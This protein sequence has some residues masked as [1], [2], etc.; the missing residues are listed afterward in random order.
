[1]IVQDQIADDIIKLISGAMDELRIGDPAS[2]ATDIGPII[3]ADA[4]ER[5]E[6]H[7]SALEKSGRVIKRMDVGELKRHGHFFGPV[8]AELPAVEELQ[9]ETFGPIIHIVRY[10]K[11]GYAD[12]ARALAGTGYGLTLGV[13][14]RLKSFQQHIRD[15]VPAGNVYV[16]R[17]IIGAVVGVQPF[18]GLGRSGTGPKAGGPHALLP[19]ATERVLTVNLLAEGADP[20]LLAL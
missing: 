12:A 19:F 3:D 9:R 13:H 18:G 2:F 5:L 1:L 11:G 14:S 4:L 17:S 7:V 20:A 15:L 16:N 10:H 6:Q 8:L